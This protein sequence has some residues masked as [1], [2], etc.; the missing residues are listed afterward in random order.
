MTMTMHMNTIY[1]FSLSL[2]LNHLVFVRDRGCD[3]MSD[4]ILI[5][6]CGICICFA[7]DLIL[8][9]SRAC[10]VVFLLFT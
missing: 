8:F 10:Q 9:L 2:S 7:Y 5:E 3:C 1:F 4:A 6:N